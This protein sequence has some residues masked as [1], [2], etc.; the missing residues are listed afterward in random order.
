MKTISG[1]SLGLLAAALI[2]T[3]SA[4]A[5]IL[6]RWTFETSIPVTA[7]PIA[8]EVGTGNASGLHAGAAV[9]SSPSGNGSLHSY[10]ANVWAVGDYWQFQSSSTGNSG[11][12]LSW[13]QT[14]SATGPR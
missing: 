8:A 6:P 11:L 3:L 7:G 5:Q 12:N 2:G 14:S 4:Q 1:F 13:D 10:S 9:Y